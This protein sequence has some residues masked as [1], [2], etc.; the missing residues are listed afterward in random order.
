M[1]SEIVLVASRFLSRFVYA[2]LLSYVTRSMSV[3][4][5]CSRF[6]LNG[7]LTLLVGL[8]VKAQG[9]C[10]C[11]AAYVQ[12]FLVLNHTSK[13]LISDALLFSDP[14]PHSSAEDVGDVTA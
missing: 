13:R 2:F 12:P 6:G 5:L 4:S 3:A 1:H 8:P 11:L 9:F 14:S 7:T 10:R